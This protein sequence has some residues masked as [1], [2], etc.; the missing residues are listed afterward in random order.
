M[1]NHT[2][3]FESKTRAVVVLTFATMLLEIGMG[4]YSHSM[5][6]LADGW[7]MA[8]HV[9]ALGLSWL[10][11][12][13]M[14][15][16]GASQRYSFNHNKLLS[17]VGFVSAIMLQLM[18]VL[19]AIQSITRFFNPQ[20]I[21]FTDA[22][23]VAVIG[24]LVN[25]LSAWMLHHK[26][27]E[28]DHNIRSAYLHVLADGLTSVMAIAALLLGMFFQIPALDSISGIISS[29]LITKWAIGLLISSG[30]RL[31]DFK[32]ADL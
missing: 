29:L 7:H 24:L 1:L 30:R 32:K 20:Q 2:H 25:G 23:V 5:A 9:L 14:R 26:A 28:S 15:K 22:L 6:L 11:Y 21:H 19:I 17:L 4:Y 18:A 3:H 10:A 31:I 27:E 12:V 13:V 16:Y 8:S